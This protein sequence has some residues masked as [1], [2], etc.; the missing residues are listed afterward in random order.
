MSVCCERCVLSNRVLCDELIT[1]PEESYRLWCI[2]VYDLE[3]S[4]IRRSWP[5]GGFCAKIKNVGHVVLADTGQKV[6]GLAVRDTGCFNSIVF[7]ENN[8][9]YF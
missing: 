8:M 3:I 7:Y 2:V 9:S 1:S 4:R 6:A 5:N